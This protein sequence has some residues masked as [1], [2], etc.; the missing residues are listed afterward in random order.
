[1]DQ[2]LYGEI[3]NELEEIQAEVLDEDEVMGEYCDDHAIEE[4]ISDL[5]GKYGINIEL[6]WLIIHAMKIDEFIKH[7]ISL[8][9]SK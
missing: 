6:D 3:L 2:S 7:V 9:K 1:M 4:I 5:N 8:V